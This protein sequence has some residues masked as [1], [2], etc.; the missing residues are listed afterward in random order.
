MRIVLKI[1]PVGYIYP[2]PCGMTD[3]IFALKPID[4]RWSRQELQLGALYVIGMHPL[5]PPL[6]RWQR[7][8]SPNAQQLEQS[9]GAIDCLRLQIPLGHYPPHC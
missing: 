2:V 4:P 7:I 6:D 9:F 1:V 3:A 8:F 5:Y